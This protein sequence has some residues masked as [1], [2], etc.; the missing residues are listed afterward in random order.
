MHQEYMQSTGNLDFS[1]RKYLL[2][3]VEQF[4]DRVSEH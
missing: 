4:Q 2:F 1:A 3:I